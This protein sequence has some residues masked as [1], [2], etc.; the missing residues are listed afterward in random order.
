MDPAAEDAFLR[1]RVRCLRHG[2]VEWTGASFRTCERTP[3]L[4]GTGILVGQ[5][6]SS[7]RERLLQA[8]TS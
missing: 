2:R 3:S 1:R 8:T 7:N 6:C 5:V 4:V